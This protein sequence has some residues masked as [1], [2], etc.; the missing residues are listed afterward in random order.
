MMYPYID[1]NDILQLSN[2]NQSNEFLELFRDVVSKW[3]VKTYSW[4]AKRGD[5]GQ[6]SI[7]F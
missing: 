4:E 5:K 7:P 3:M 6:F 1:N 2:C